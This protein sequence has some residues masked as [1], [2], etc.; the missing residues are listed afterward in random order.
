MVECTNVKVNEKFGAK[1]RMLDYNSDEEE[2]NPKPIIENVETFFETKNL[3]LQNDVQ[4]VELREEPRSEPREE[5]TYESVTP[6]PN[7]N[8]TKNH[9]AN[10]IIGSKE[11]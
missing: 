6:T 5:V 2:A 4:I 3:D 7:R 1:E 10:Q 9:P 8:S 11:K